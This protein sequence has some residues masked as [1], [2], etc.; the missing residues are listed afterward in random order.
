MQEWLAC[1]HHAR[2]YLLVDGLVSEGLILRRNN[3][4]GAEVAFW[5]AGPV[6]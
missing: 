6:A 2:D 5:T 1:Q 4:H 3:S